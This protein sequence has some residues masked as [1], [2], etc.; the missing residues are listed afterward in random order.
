MSTMKRTKPLTTQPYASLRLT[1]LLFPALALV[2]DFDGA[3]RQD[4]GHYEEEYT[5][6]HASC[7]GLVLHSSGNRELHLLAALVAL[8]GVRQY[9]EVV[10][11]TSY[12]VFHCRSRGF[13][14]LL[15]LSKKIVTEI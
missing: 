13:Y 11:P 8:H 3:H 9:A 10:R 15:F 6:D 14:L 4:D 5:S 12:Q 1:F 7:D 2:A